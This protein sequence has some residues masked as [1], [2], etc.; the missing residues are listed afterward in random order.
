MK[1]ISDYESKGRTSDKLT[2]DKTM[3][4]VDNFNIPFSI[5]IEQADKK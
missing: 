3:V 4:A 5:I 2:A 1:I